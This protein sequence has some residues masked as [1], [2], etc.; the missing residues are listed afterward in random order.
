ME[1]VK[2]GIAEFI[3]EF[4]RR[5]LPAKRRHLHALSSI[6]NYSKVTTKIFYYYFTTRGAGHV[7]S[8]QQMLYGV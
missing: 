5:R 2:N 6:I 1:G 7:S 4:M 8:E 3:T